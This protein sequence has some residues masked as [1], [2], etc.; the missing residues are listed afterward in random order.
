MLLLAIAI[1]FL[2]TFFVL[3]VIIRAFKSINLL[4]APDRRKIHK[5]STPSLGGIAIMLGILISL[6]ITTPFSE[7]AQYKFLL[8]GAILMFILGIRDDISSLNAN[9]KLTVQ[10]LSAFLIVYFT[11][12]KITGFYGIFGIGE[13]NEILAIIFS[14]FIIVALTNAFN[15]IDGIDGLAGSVAFVASVFLGVWFFTSDNNLLS[16]ISLTIASS[17]LAFLFFNWHPSKIFMGDTGSIVLGFLLSSLCIL[18]INSANNNAS[19]IISINAPVAVATALL[20]VPIYDTLRVFSMRIA[21]GKSPFVP[22][23][24]HIHHILLKQG[25]N[26]RE[27]TMILMVFN[28]LIIALTFL[29]QWAG[30]TILLIGQLSLAFAAGTFLDRRL[31]KYLKLHLR[32]ERQEAFRVSKSA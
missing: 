12:V 23:R 1:S 25:F 3:P 30:E 24:K 21:E 6:F 31:K 9:Q 20:I 29:F 26:H 11:G 15:L 5:V 27:A 7:L 4:D 14:T 10:V 8:G 16:V 22:D 19:P 13:I 28:L 32:K 17:V 2:V 18:F